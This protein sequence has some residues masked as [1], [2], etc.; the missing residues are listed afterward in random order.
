MN[1]PKLHCRGLCHQSCGPIAISC[2]EF[3]TLKGIVGERIQGEPFQ[4]GMI[5][6]NF[7]PKTYT[8]P[9]LTPGKRCSVYEHR[10]MICRIWGMTKKLRCP[11]GCR[12]SRWLSESEAR[13]LL[14]Q[15]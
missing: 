13:V 2:A 9:L 7:D 12:P 3:D 15:K 1:L 10:P 5:I 8:C 14:G 11:F 4:G 6:S